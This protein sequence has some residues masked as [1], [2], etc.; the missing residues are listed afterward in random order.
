VQKQDG[1][2]GFD[3]R[4][5]DIQLASC[6]H[7]TS[8]AKMDGAG[9]PFIIIDVPWRGVSLAGDGL[10]VCL[11]GAERV[12]GQQ[13]ALWELVQLQPL[14]NALFVQDVEWF[15]LDPLKVR[16]DQGVWPVRRR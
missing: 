8:Q 13:E 9:V 6:L 14:S 2:E 12:D 15:I 5:V 1:L 4:L 3:A 7:C 11:P 10:A 16:V